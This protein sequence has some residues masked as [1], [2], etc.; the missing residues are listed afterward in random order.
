MGVSSIDSISSDGSVSIAGKIM[1]IREAQGLYRYTI[2][3]ETGHVEVASYSPFELGD[4]VKVSGDV[5]KHAGHF[6]I[7]AT[8]MDRLL[9]PA[10]G[11]VEKAI[12]LSI[13]KESMPR[14]CEPL[15]NDE[16]MRALAKPSDDCARRIRRAIFSFRPILI[17]YNGDADGICAGLALKRAIESV[18]GGDV[19]RRLFFAQNNPAIYS[20]GD[21]LRDI[22][23]IRMLPERM[24]KPL[25]LLVDFAA[26]SE[27]VEAL[28]LVK[29]AGVELAIIDHH[30]FDSKAPTLLDC[31]VSPLTCNGTSHYCAGLLA[32]EVAKRVSDVDVSDLQRTA[33]AGD[34]SRLAAPSEEHE[35]LATAVDFLAIYQKDT[36]TLDFF[37]TSFQDKAF[38]ESVYNQA[39][40]K[41]RQSH[42]IAKE[43]VKIKDL[44]NGFKLCKIKLDAAAKKGEFPTKGKTTGSIHDELAAQNDVPI[45]TL[46]YGE[47]MISIRANLK[48]KE[49][50]FNASRMIDQLKAE[51]KNAVESGG[52][53]DV[54]ASIKVNKGF[55]KIVLDWVCS[56]IERI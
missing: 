20:P 15:V 21:A 9:D 35:R 6:D 51:M 27:S 23:I 4:V 8:E 25:F 1:R 48:A 40:A 41:M 17:R 11:L 26:N 28:E 46:G 19:K 37:D 39:V 55:G 44:P 7:Y 3:D 56:W 38:M 16:V 14:K 34:K 31:F 47:R 42:A 12:E 36:S 13:E 30:P 52:G 29:G 10:R 43:F 53:H 32:G 5:K 24:E 2:A 54:A 50:G 18:M 22:S 49:R 33:M 45:V